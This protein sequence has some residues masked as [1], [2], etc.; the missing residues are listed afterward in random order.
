MKTCTKCGETKPLEDF[1][2]DKR[3]KDGRYSHCK[4]CHLDCGRS[5][6]SRN[7]DAAKR[8]YQRNRVYESERKKRLRREQPEVLRE[9]WDRYY[10]K[11]I[12][13]IEAARAARREEA[14]QRTREWQRR[15]PEK[16]RIHSNNRRARKVQAPGNA[17]F[18]DV[19][20]LLNRYQHRCAYCG[21][22]DRIQI[23]HVVPLNR[24]GTNYI[25]NLLPACKRC[26]CSKNDRLL[27]EWRYRAGG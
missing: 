14:V 26:N 20:R 6:R 25:G 19:Q 13:K 2:S 27:V 22:N 7:P 9:R 16:V 15:N 18:E 11:N 3:R 5:W 24:G 10:K 4:P 23:D 1:Y 12:T 17:S 8:A 21:S